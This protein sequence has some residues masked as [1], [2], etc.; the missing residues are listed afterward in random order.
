MITDFYTTEFTN[1]RAV[2]TTD[3][4][5]NPYSEQEVVGQFNGHIQQASPEYAESL[6]LAFYKAYAIWCPLNTDIIEGD[7]LESDIGTFAVRAI[8]VYMVGTNKHLELV[9]EKIV[10]LEGS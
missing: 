6:G 9:A 3:I 5:Q 2:W 8:M 1:L 7:T 10:D 4:E